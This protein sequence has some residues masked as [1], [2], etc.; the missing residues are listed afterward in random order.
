MVKRTTKF[1]WRRRFRRKQQQVE[2]LGS[3]ADV[4]IERHL[5]R[6]FNRFLGVR[7]FVA[8]WLLLF[9]FLI[10]GTILQTRALSRYYQ[11]LEPGTGGVYA[12]GIYGTFTNA[13]PIYASSRVDTSVARLVFSSLMRYDSS[14]KLVGD[15]AQSVDVDDT[16]SIY[17][18][19]L[20]TDALWHDGVTV[21]ADDVVFTYKTI[22]KSDA[23]SPLFSNWKNVKI[24][25]TSKNK[26][27][28]ELPLALASFPHSLTNGIVP[29]HKLQGID[30]T[31]LRSASFNTVTPVGSGPFKWSAVEVGGDGVDNR[32]ERIG[33]VANNGYYH[34]APKLERFNLRVFHNKDLLVQALE[35][36]ELNAA[37]GLEASPESMKNSPNATEYDV[38][39]AAGVMVFM[40]NKTE[41]LSDPKVRRALTRATKRTEILQSLGYPVAIV[42][43]P[44]LKSHFAYDPDQ[45]QVAFNPGK[46]RAELDKAGWK[47]KGGGTR[48][49]GGEKLSV[50]ITTQEGT[51]YQ[52]IAE[53]LKDQ[54]AKVGVEVRLDLQTDSSLQSAIA[55][56][57]YDILLYGITIGSDPDVY[58]FWH[59]SQADPRS[60]NRLNFSEYKD[61]AADASLEAGRSRSGEKLRTTKYKPFLE[62]WRQDAPAI[63]LYQP[64]FLY[65][66]SGNLFGFK[67]QV[68]NTP[69]DRFANVENWAVRQERVDIY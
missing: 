6:R 55:G 22:Q 62:A 50:A 4:H 17:T 31:Q 21:S 23:K 32:E 28:F 26:V 36:G 59:S 56:H 54:W 11:T 48:V 25:K 18:V 20:R 12:E 68:F 34:G 51:E 43:S 33:L 61:S 41:P 69:V 53:L 3:Q 47:A 39:L 49:K 65:I 10:G 5:L 8:S 35:D 16:G 58:A 15:L 66:V 7:R 19:T 52:R 42:D 40:K 13:N 67:P 37:V 9:I 45:T 14:N 2:K 29:R 63:G 57:G 27:K 1:K 24:T 64:R 46:A 30:P 38:P 44:M 60:P